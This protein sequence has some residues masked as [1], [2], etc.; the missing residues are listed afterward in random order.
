MPKARWKE[1]ERAEAL[2]REDDRIWAELRDECAARYM[3][4]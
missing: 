2:T 4:L 3:N 1:I